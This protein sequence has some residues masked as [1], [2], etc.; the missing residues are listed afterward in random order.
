MQYYL[1]TSKKP[2]TRLT[3]TLVK[4]LHNLS[5]G[6][7]LLSW[8]ASYLIP[9]DNLFLLMTFSLI[10]VSYLLAFAE[11]T[12]DLYYSSSLFYWLIMSNFLK[13]TSMMI[14]RWYLWLGKTTKPLISANILLSQSFSQLMW[15]TSTIH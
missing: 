15:I 13:I 3:M 6:N 7:P 1:L 2:L 4:I 9:E 11:V 5:I 10:F 8:L 14:D 12:L